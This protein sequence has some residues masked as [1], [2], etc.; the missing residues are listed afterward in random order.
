[1]IVYNS[2]DELGQL[3]AKKVGGVPGIDYASTAGLQTVDYTYNVR[4]WLKMINQDQNNDNDLFNFSLNY[5]DPTLSGATALFNGNISE[6]HWETAND[7]T[8]RNYQYNYDALNRIE[9]ATGSSTNYSLTN[10]DYDKNGN[11][12]AL[13]RNGHTNSGA[14]SFGAMDNLVYTYDSGNK[15][16]NVADNNASDSYGFV[17][18]NGSGT[19]YTY[20]SNGNLT[21][22]LNKGITDIDYNHLNLPTQVTVSNSEHSGNVQFIYAADGTKLRKIVSSTG[23]TTDYAGSFVYENGNLAQFG[24]PEGYIEPDGS[25]GYDYFYNYLDHLGSVRLTYS[26]FNG[27]GSIEPSSEIVMERNTY[28]FGMPHKGYNGGINGRENN[29]QTY[30]GQEINKELGLDW[31][32]FRYR[33]YMPEIGRFFGVDPISEEY[34]SI[35]TYQFAHNSPVWK[36][37]LEGLEGKGTSKPDYLAGPNPLPKNIQK[38]KEIA[39]RPKRNVFSGTATLR[40]KY[41]SIGLKGQL[42]TS[43]VKVNVSVAEGKVGTTVDNE[44]TTLDGTLNVVKISS[45][46]KVGEIGKAKVSGTLGKVEG[47]LASNGENEGEISLGTYDLSSTIGNVTETESGNILSSNEENSGVQ[48]SSLKLESEDTTLS[49]KDS[50]IGL[51]VN[52]GPANLSGS[53]NLSEAGKWINDQIEFFTNLFNNKKD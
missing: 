45:E 21:S 9:R 22:D 27:N 25:G 30:L 5:N 46:I 4:G 2:Y 26:D 48:N 14:T 44:K 12:T 11:I 17:D 41:A 19:E 39:S 3:Q 16:T 6:T 35:S 40:G 13:A 23:A 38:A 43:G 36:I 1:L 15:L 37:E 50:K 28:P 7:N 53:M 32:T 29:Y 51:G 52:A 18:V 10:V 33:N 31:L 34:F 42:G 20:D 49:L 47:T 8:A 24:Q